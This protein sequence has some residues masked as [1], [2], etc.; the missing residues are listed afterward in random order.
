MA[1][2]TARTRGR[3]ESR[4]DELTAGIT[5]SRLPYDPEW[6]HHGF[7]LCAAGPLILLCPFVW[8]SPEDNAK[9]QSHTVELLLL[10]VVLEEKAHEDHFLF[11]VVWRKVTF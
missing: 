2:H 6:V 1:T 3:R 11:P 9:Q 4:A 10:F 5:G 8:G 7:P